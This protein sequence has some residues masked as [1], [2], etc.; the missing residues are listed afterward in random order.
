[1]LYKGMEV[2]HNGRALYRVVMTA[3]GELWAREYRW[4]KTLGS[5]S[6]SSS[7]LLYTHEQAQSWIDNKRE[8]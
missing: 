6:L 4:S 7:H 3:I 5:W 8:A 1:M 2:Y